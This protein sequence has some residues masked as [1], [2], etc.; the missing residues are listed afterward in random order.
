MTFAGKFFT[1]E[2]ER[3]SRCIVV[4]IVVSFVSVCFG[5]LFLFPKEGHKGRRCFGSFRS[6]PNQALHS[7]ELLVRTD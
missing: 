5:L 4:Q 1:E 3:Q 2:M 6:L 7:I